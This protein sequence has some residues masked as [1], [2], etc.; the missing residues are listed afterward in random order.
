VPLRSCEFEDDRARCRDVRR[1]LE[2]W[3]D[4]ATL[5]ALWDRT[6]NQWKHLLGTNIEVA[7]TFLQSGKYRKRRGEWE[8][9]RWET[10]LPSRLEVKQPADF[11]QQVEMARSNYRR[12]TLAPE[13]SSR[14]L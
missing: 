13:F 3:L 2:F 6:W 12:R 7:G 10:A 5:H 8:L 14:S 4:S 11:Q 1:K 9:V